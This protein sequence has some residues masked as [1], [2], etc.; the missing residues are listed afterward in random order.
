MKGKAQ[1]RSIALKGWIDAKTLD[2]ETSLE[3]RGIEIK[4]FEPYYRKRVTAEIE[5]G[6]LDMDSRIVV[7]EKRLDAPGELDLINL[8]IKDGGGTVF[9]IPVENLV[10]FLRKKGHQIKAKFHVKGNVEDP[11]FNLQE[12][13]LTQVAISFVRA[14]G[15]PID[16]IGEKAV[17]NTLTGEK[18]LAEELR[19]IERLFKKKKEKKR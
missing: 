1:E 9:W 15:Y 17:Q 2:M 19:S 16:V 11:R 10:S 13:F 6:T 4:A 18:G 14:L 3:I 7:K 8:H 12:T 5:S